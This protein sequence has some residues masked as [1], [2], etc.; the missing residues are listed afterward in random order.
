MF[1][2]GRPEFDKPLVALLEN[3]H[4]LPEDLVPLGYGAG[5]VVVDSAAAEIVQAFD[6][7]GIFVVEHAGCHGIWEAS[8]WII[9]TLISREGHTLPG[10]V[11]APGCAQG[12]ATKLGVVAKETG[13]AAVTIALTVPLVVPMAVT[14]VT[15]AATMITVTALASM[16]G[17]SIQRQS[18]NSGNA[19]VV[20]L[21]D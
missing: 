11:D 9:P 20:L 21:R 4:R 10:L 8:V 1:I 6:A 5:S 7:P 17:F 14:A 19:E 12:L 16:S 18:L 13:T 2:L 3:S 15:S